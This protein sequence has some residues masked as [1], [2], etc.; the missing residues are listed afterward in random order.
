LGVAGPWF[1]RAKESGPQLN[2]SLS[3]WKNHEAIGEIPTR[4]FVGMTAIDAFSFGL[5]LAT[6]NKQL[7]TVLSKDGSMLLDGQRRT[8]LI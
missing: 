2:G 7:A 4:N 5:Q 8:A 1:E 3:I 6:W